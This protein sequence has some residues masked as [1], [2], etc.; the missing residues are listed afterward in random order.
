VHDHVTVFETRHEARLPVICLDHWPDFQTAAAENRQLCR[1]VLNRYT[2]AL[3]AMKGRAPVYVPRV[4]RQDGGY[5][6]AGP[7]SPQDELLFPALVTGF[8]RYIAVLPD[9]EHREEAVQRFSNPAAK[10]GQQLFGA[11][12]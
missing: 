11:Q 12:P 6:A 10:L 3:D 7:L 4:E 9:G 1:D 2:Q 8:E 5:T